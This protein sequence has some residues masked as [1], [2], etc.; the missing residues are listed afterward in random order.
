MDSHLHETETIR[1][2]VIPS[3]IVSDTW[4]TVLV[5]ERL[6]AIHKPFFEIIYDGDISLLRIEIEENYDDFVGFDTLFVFDGLLHHETD[7]MIEEQ[8][9]Y[10]YLFIKTSINAAVS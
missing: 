1:N 5:D 2:E 10:Q 8:A 6:Y 3:D 4:I 9:G 7:H